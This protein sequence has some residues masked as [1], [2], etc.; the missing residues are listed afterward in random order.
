MCLAH[1]M[2][3]DGLK[4]K[5]VDMLFTSRPHKKANCTIPYRLDKVVEKK[6]LAMASL[7][8]CPGTALVLL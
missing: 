4:T 1:G 8:Y 3:G 6:M 5:N 2:N 7:R